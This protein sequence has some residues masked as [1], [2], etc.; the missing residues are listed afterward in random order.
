MAEIQFIKEGPDK[1]GTISI[2]EG[3]VKPGNVF[4]VKRFICDVC[5]Q[6]TEKETEAIAD[7][8]LKKL[9]AKKSD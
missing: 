2:I 6:Q 8:L 3:T 7:L 9:N 4:S 5:P 1:R